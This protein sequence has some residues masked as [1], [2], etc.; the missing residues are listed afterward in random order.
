MR[1][2]IDLWPLADL[3]GS[4]PR[5]STLEGHSIVSEIVVDQSL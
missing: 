5:G 2:T 4:P 1:P 3:F